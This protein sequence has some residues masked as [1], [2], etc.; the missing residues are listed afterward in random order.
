MLDVYFFRLL[1]ESNNN[2]TGYSNNLRQAE[3]FLSSGQFVMPPGGVKSGLKG[4]LVYLSKKPTLED[5]DATDDKE[6]LLASSEDDK[7]I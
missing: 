6:E 3:M 1:A 2:L 5:D 7:S 4:Q